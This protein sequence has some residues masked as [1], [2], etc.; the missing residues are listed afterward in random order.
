MIEMKKVLSLITFLMF[1]AI[2]FAQEEQNDSI[3]KP[4]KFASWTISDA[5]QAEAGFAGSYWKPTFNIAF[6]KEGYYCVVNLYNQ[7]GYYSVDTETLPHLYLKTENGEIVDLEMDGDEPIHKFYLSGYY[8]ARVWMPGRYVTRFIYY[9]PDIDEFLS[10]YYIK[11]RVFG[12][13][14]SFAAA[15][16]RAFFVGT[17]QTKTLTLNSIVMVLSNVLFNWILVFGKLGLPAM[18]ISGAAIG[19]VLAEAVSLAFFIIYTK[20]RINCRK[21]GLDTVYKPS[22]AMQGNILKISFWTMIQNFISFST[23]FAFIIFV[24]H[25]GEH[26]LAITNIVRNIASIVFMIITAFSSTCSSVTSNLIGAARQEEVMPTIK[27]IIGMAYMFAIPL[28]ILFSA[29]PQTFARIYTN[30][31]SLYEAVAPSVWVFC[32]SLLF[33]VPGNILFQSVSGTGNTRKA[34]ALEIGTLAVYLAYSAFVTLQLH[35]D[36][37]LCWT[38]EHVYYILIGIL[39]YSYIRKG[40]WA[41][42]RV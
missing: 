42:K 10:K 6:D 38:T 40:K 33:T 18:G 30:I 20:Y 39:S 14:F 24:E 1:Y 34:F 25:L 27:R 2:S 22:A 23:W 4:I 16:F 36:V 37:S 17:T 3:Q 41:G 5:F 28:A 31:P 19:S 7:S 21:Y 32:T 12:L 29:F 9:I 15:M 8:V 11:Y 26:P 13:I 35:L